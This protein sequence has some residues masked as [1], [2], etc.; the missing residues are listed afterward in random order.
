M[1]TAI[2]IA[3][4][5]ES[6][7][8]IVTF[9]LFITI[10]LSFGRQTITNIILGLYFAFLFS[11][12]F[13]YYETILAKTDSIKAE[14]GLIIAIFLFF[15]IISTL[16]FV[17]I[18]PREYGE[19]TFEGF[20]KKVILALAGTVVVASFSYHAIPVTD[21]ITP[22]SPVSYLFGSEKSFFWWLLAPIVVLF[23]A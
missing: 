21:L 20:G 6:L 11:L 13:P 7:F 3:F 9:V 2:L 4:V 14:S 1:D 17:R 23:V 19:K 16:L 12:Q 22:G 15:T 10:A 5:Q 18:L 8:L